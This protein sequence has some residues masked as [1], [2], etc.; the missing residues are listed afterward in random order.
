MFAAGIF[1]S[2]SDRWAL[3]WLLF[4][5]IGASVF[6]SA[7]PSTAAWR[8]KEFF[9]TAWFPPPPTDEAM[10]RLAAEGYNLT[11]TPVE[12]L[13]AVARHHLRAMLVNDLLKP[14]VLDDPAKRQQLDALIE[15]VK[16][17]P[18]LN[19]YF[20]EDEPGAKA[21]R[22]WGRLV[23]YLKARDPA[24]L[25]YINLFPTYANEQQLGVSADAADR[26]RVGYPLN[27][28]GVGT[29]DQT[30]LRYREHL[31]LFVETVK[32]ELLSYDHYHFLKPDKDGKPVDGSQ[33]FLNLA[34]IRMAAQE[35]RIPFLNTIQAGVNLD[36]WRL[37][38]PAEM[39]WLIL[40]TMAHGGRGISYF[41]YW[42]FRGALYVGGKPSPLARPVAALNAE[43]ARL[44]P[45]LLELDSVGVYHTAPLPYGTE[46]IPGNCPVQIVG[47][48]GFVLGLFGKSGRA[49]A[50][51]IVNRDYSRESE[52]VVKVLL[53]GRRLQELD[54]KTGKWSPGP[55]LNESR[56]VKLRLKPGDGRLFRANPAPVRLQAPHDST[57][58]P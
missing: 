58:W 26:A 40:T 52:A 27:F 46:L 50:F 39:R 6:A 55:P 10:A 14:E 5:S 42:D 47:G 24:H 51:M 28:A 21:F 35:A 49:N 25:A 12:G 32:P 48:G 38:S 11:Q 31:K 15:R 36:G 16:Q 20:L 7:S 37:P 19:A 9:V 57:P 22:G 4:A 29:D 2:R 44:G 53:P 23:A 8:Q 54:H 13:D 3:R 34:L 41:S 56:T 43:I 17:H 18:A 33:Y 1:S 45:A 30:V